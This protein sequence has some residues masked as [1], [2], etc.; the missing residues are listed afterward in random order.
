[1]LGNGLRQLVCLLF[2]LAAENNC[3]QAGTFGIFHASTVNVKWYI[4]NKNMS[5]FVYHHMLQENRNV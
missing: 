5:F 4:V 3:P 2:G 1:L